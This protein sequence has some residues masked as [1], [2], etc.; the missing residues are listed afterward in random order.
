MNERKIK[1]IIEEIYQKG[2]DG[3]IIK[4]I[5]NIGY[6]SNY[7]PTAFAV[8]LLKEEPVIY[9]TIMDLEF[10]ENSSDIEVKTFKS[11]KDLKEILNKENYKKIAVEKTLDIET[12]QKISGE[13]ELIISDLLEKE[14]MIKTSDE[15]AKIKK[16]TD[17]AHKSFNEVKEDMKNKK[18]SELAISYKL[19]QIL[20]DNGAEGESF[21][22]IIASS[23]STSLPHSTPS[24]NK[25]DYPILVDWGA[26][27]HNYCSDTTRTIVYSEKEEEIFNIVLEAY[28]KTIKSIKPGIKSCNLD[29][30]ARDIITEYGYGENFI[31]TTGHSLGLDIHEEPRIAKNDKTIIEKNMV[32][33]IE[34]GIYLK[35]EF[36]VRIEDTIHVSNRGKVIGNLNPVI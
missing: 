27:Y 14:R 2:F 22:T 12:Y 6:I 34:P 5:N 21:D 17:I 31:H 26:K 36:G 1:T 32:F 9:T 20:R 7:F 13:Y 10:A 33:T 8:C 18:F 4:D 29:K 23:S 35:G 16:A 15:I 19:G 25:I 30:I 3:M 28:N 24:N 11:L